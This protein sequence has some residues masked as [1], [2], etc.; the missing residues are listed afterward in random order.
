MVVVVDVYKYEFSNNSFKI[1]CMSN[2]YGI[3]EV[4]CKKYNKKLFLVLIVGYLW[5]WEVYCDG[6]EV[7]SLIKL[8][9]FRGVVEKWFD[10]WGEKVGVDDN[11]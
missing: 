7:D 10:G 6:E 1:G 2:Y 11:G 5:Y 4:N 9:I 3:S 8:Y